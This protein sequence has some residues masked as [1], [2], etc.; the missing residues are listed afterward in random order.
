MFVL[1]GYHRV[2]DNVMNVSPII[3]SR[4]ASMYGAVLQ[5]LAMS[6]DVRALLQLTS[7]PLSTLAPSVHELMA[8]E[9]AAAGLEEVKEPF[10]W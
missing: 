3:L 9:R 1:A 5:Q 2:C 7:P 10:I 8:L 4:L 6:A